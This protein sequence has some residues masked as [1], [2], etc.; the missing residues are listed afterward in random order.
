MNDIHINFKKNSDMGHV[1]E[2]HG[3]GRDGG[4]SKAKQRLSKF[5]FEVSELLLV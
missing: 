1:N 5:D 3:H 4:L 2:W